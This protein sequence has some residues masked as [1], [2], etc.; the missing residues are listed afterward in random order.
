M[1]TIKMVAAAYGT[2]CPGDVIDNILESVER[3]G[4]GLPVQGMGQLIESMGLQTQIGEVK[5]DLVKELELPV[6]IKEQNYFALLTEATSTNIVI[7]DPEKGWVK[8][9]NDELREKIGEKLKVILVKKVADTPQKTFGW[10]WFTPVVKKFKWPLVASFI[11]IT[12][13]TIIQ[14]A[15]P[16]YSTIIDSG[17]S[18]AATGARR[19]ISRFS[20]AQGVLTSVRTWLL[21]DTTD[22]MDLIL[23]SQ[24]IDKLLVPLRFLRKDR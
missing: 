12:I 18:T 6:I 21:I 5:I 24:V 20:L 23:G 10:K 19:S 13:Y 2:P 4:T 16:A 1:A 8:L 17:K 11:S 3:K 7:A 22:R 15:N 14:L 9:N